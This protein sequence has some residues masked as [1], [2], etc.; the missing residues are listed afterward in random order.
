MNANTNKNQQPPLHIVLYQPQIP[1]NTGNIGRLCACTN[2]RLHLV[3]PLGFSLDNRQL[4]RAGLDYWPHL[5]VQEHNNW[6]E[7]LNSLDSTN[8]RWFALTTKGG[9][10]LW[11][12][13]FKAGDVLVFGRETSGLPA[14]IMNS[15]RINITGVRIPMRDDAP[16]RSLNLA[17]ACAIAIYEALRQQDVVN[18]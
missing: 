15:D 4:K 11:D 12:C 7:L 14:E 6:Q 3:H 2:C 9:V 17:N 16:I 10:G 18:P 13:Q 5:D 8:K 1:P